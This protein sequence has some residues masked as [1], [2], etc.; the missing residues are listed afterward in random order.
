MRVLSV[1]VFILCQF[2]SFSQIPPIYKQALAPVESRV[3]DLMARMTPE[4]KFWQLF[5]I[6]GEIRSGEE[7]KYVNGIFG[8]QVSAAS[9]GGNASAQLLTY[10]ATDD[11]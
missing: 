4:E 8:F 1:I 5:M 3:K 11:A 10:N 7:A 2:H 9:Q 6:P